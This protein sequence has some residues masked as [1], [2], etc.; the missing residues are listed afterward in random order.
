MDFSK[1]RTRPFACPERD[2]GAA[3]RPFTKRTIA[4]STAEMGAKISPICT[5]SSADILRINGSDA[6]QEG[7]IAFHQPEKFLL[8]KF[9]CLLFGPGPD[10]GAGFKALIQEQEACPL[11]KKLCRYF[12][13]SEIRQERI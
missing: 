12:S 1:C 13:Y 5:K 10:E 11:P 3:H 7:I 4:V 6:G 2:G 9:S 8:G